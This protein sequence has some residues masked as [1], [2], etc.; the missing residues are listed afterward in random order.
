VSVLHFPEDLLPDLD[1]EMAPDDGDPVIKID[2]RHGPGVAEVA[3]ERSQLSVFG[4]NPFP[5]GKMKA[6]AARHTHMRTKS[7]LQ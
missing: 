6:A 1:R 7:K 4:D 5:A 2:F 3:L